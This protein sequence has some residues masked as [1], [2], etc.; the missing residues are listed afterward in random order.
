MI[1]RL[2][3]CVPFGVRRGSTKSVKFQPRTYYRK[4]LVPPV[5]SDR[6][7]RYFDRHVHFTMSSEKYNLELV[8]VLQLLM[9]GDDKLLMHPQK[10]LLLYQRYVFIK[11][12]WTWKWQMSLR[13]GSVRIW[14]NGFEIYIPMA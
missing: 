2:G 5:N 4:E 13:H 3:N 6:S 11:I 14:K 12:L 8:E 9:S 7:F 1:I 10:N